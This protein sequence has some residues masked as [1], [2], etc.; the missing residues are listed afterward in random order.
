MAVAVL[1]GVYWLKVWISE[2]SLSGDCI[3]ITKFCWC[4]CLSQKDVDFV[5]AAG[6]GVLELARHGCRLKSSKYKDIKN[7]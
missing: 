2:D 7:M 6:L 3:Q 4:L 1:D 5:F